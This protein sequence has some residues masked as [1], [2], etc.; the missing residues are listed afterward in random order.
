MANPIFEINGIIVTPPEGWQGIQILSTFDDADAQANISTTA[1]TFV[2]D[3][4]AVVKNYVAAGNIFEGLPLKITVHEPNVGSATVF[5]GIIDLT[6]GYE[7]LSINDTNQ[8]I[9]VKCN[10]KIDQDIFTVKERLN[11]LTWG[12]LESDG[13][14]TTADYEKLVYK[15]Q[16]EFDFLESALLGLQI[17]M[18]TT[19][20]IRMTRIIAKFAGDA[21]AHGTGGLSGPPTAVAYTIAI[22]LVHL[23]HATIIIVQMVNLITRLIATIFP[24]PKRMYIMSAVK[25]M[26][27]ACAKLGYTFKTSIP[28]LNEMRVISSK[29]ERGIEKLFSLN[30][31]DSGILRTRDAGFICGDFFGFMETMFNARMKKTGTIIEMETLNNDG[32]WLQQSTYKMPSVLNSKK[33]F[34]TEDMKAT[35]LISFQTDPADEWTVAE[36]DGT[37]YEIQTKIKNTVGTTDRIQLKGLDNIQ[38][39]FALAHNSQN[40]SVLEFAMKQLIA[41]AFKFADLFDDVVPPNLSPELFSIQYAMKISHPY[42]SV[43][44]VCLVQ[45]FTGGNKVLKSTN[46]TDLSA[47]KLYTSFIGEKSFVSNN[48]RGQWEIYEDIRINFGFTDFLTLTKNSY[49]YDQDG[50]TGKVDSIKWQMGDDYAI[51]NYRLRKPYT[52]NLFETVH[53]PK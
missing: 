52:T 35:R 23:A 12:L 25:M 43:P 24:I 8:A 20:G 22:G 26:E 48:F 50:E 49:F 5:N 51:V 29:E 34:N 33:R 53:K 42:M 39:P 32:F 9:K 2:A 46:R 27:K 13:D 19:E 6:E 40:P 31:D 47:Q 21:V 38:V 28:L 11:G 14:I 44:K 16:K 37:S 1:F 4:A 41:T 7:D 15:V 45:D 18:I 17:Y 36:H 10:I 30:K 3:A